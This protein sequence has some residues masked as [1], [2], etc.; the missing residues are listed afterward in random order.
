L[1]LSLLNHWFANCLSQSSTMSS[2]DFGT[3][4][5]CHLS[6]SR[7]AGLLV[8]AVS[9]NEW[10]AAPHSFCGEVVVAMCVST[11]HY[12]YTTHTWLLVGCGLS[13]SRPSKLSSHRP[14]M[15]DPAQPPAPKLELKMLVLPVMFLFQK[16]VDFKD[17]QILNAA[18]IGLLSVA[19]IALGTYFMIKQSIDRKNNQKK[20]WI[21]PKAPPS[22]PFLSPPSEGP[23]KPEDYTETTY[24]DHEQKLVM[25]AIQGV[26]LSCGIAAFMSFKFDVHF[27]CL[28]QAVMVPLGLYEN[29]L[30]QKYIFGS[31]QANLYNELETPPAPGAVAVSATEEEEEEEL[32]RVE[33]LDEEPKTTTSTGTTEEKK[34]EVHSSDDDDTVKVEKSDANDID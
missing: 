11:H 24:H 13:L 9:W 23:P 15:T 14:T 16:Q 1:L 7:S 10:R 25:E 17:P 18:R 4:T 19:V 30:V 22:I 34:D 12:Q 21:P 33:E 3:N 8:S 29:I 2:H 26:V 32:P 6:V 28:M 27:S 5:L 31:T 20:I